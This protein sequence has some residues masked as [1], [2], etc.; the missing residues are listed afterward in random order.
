MSLK[1][2]P[3]QLMNGGSADED[4]GSVD[5]RFG[6]VTAA[7]FSMSRLLDEKCRKKHGMK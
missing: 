1:W 4:D 3:N 5:R 6:G 2:T 7:D